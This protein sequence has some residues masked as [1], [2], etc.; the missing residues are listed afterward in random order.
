MSVESELVKWFVKE[1][2]PKDVLN[3]HGLIDSTRTPVLWVIL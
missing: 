3:C 2:L 1:K